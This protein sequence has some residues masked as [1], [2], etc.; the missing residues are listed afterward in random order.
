MEAVKVSYWI[1]L[2]LSC[3]AISKHHIRVTLGHIVMRIV[4]VAFS[5]MF[6]HKNMVLNHVKG[7]KQRWTSHWVKSN[8]NTMLSMVRTMLKM[9]DTTLKQTNAFY[10]LLISVY[11]TQYLLLPRNWFYTPI[12]KGLSPH[13]CLNRAWKVVL[14]P[15][16]AF[17]QL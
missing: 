14:S 15:V 6:V 12:K 3:Q 1:M 8:A 10:R 7:A 4:G 17:I 16:I 2:M 9:L 5:T 13:L 11:F